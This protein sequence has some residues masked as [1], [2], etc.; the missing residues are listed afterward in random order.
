MPAFLISNA[1]HFESL[2]Q[3]PDGPYVPR[4]PWFFATSVTLPSSSVA[5]AS[6]FARSQQRTCFPSG[7]HEG[8]W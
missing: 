8:S 7:L 4:L 1:I 5:K 3:A 2:D 6:R